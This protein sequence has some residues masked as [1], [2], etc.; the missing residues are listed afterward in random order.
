MAHLGSEAAEEGSWLLEKAPACP[1]QVNLVP[2]NEPLTTANL[3]LPVFF[4]VEDRNHM[5]LI[6]GWSTTDL[7]DHMQDSHDQ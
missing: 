5:H 1:T 6:Q 7:N 2:V 3:E 4:N